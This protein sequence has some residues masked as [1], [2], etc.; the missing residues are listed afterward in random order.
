MRAWT[1]RVTSKTVR[2]RVSVGDAGGG[3]DRFEFLGVVLGTG[4]PGPGGLEVAVRRGFARSGV[5]AAPALLVQILG[6]VRQEGEQRERA[7]DGDDLL[8]AEIGEQR[9]HLVAVGMRAADG[10]G[11]AAGGL[12]QVE[13]LLARLLTHGVAQQGAEEPDVV[14]KRGDGLLERV[15]LRSLG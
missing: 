3:A 10:E 13:D 8:R 6:H 4:Q 11:R 14:P 5:D 9:G 15:W 2:R 7:D 12:H 1:R